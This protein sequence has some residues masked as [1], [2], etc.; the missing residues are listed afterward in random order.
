VDLEG[1]RGDKQNPSTIASAT[2]ALR[3]IH[4]AADA[5]LPTVSRTIVTFQVYF[6]E[7]NLYESLF[8]P[9]DFVSSFVQQE[10]A[11]FL[12]KSSLDQ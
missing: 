3:R 10:R 7:D 4:K 11:I 6:H 8:L 5:G 9:V 1:A 12:V 2:G